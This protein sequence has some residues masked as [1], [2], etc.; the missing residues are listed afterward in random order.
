MTAEALFKAMADR[1]RQR[2][3]MVLRKQE[4]NVT[5]LVEVL[6]QPQSTVSRHLKILRDAGLIRDRRNGATILY[7][8]PVAEVNGDAADL[9]ARLLEWSSIQPLAAS[10]EAR[11]DAVIRLRSDMSRRFFDRVGEQWDGLREE[12]FGSSFH[13]E[14]FIT[15]LPHAWAVADIGTGTGYLLPTLARHFRCVIGVDPVDRM[16]ET[17]RR[18]VKHDGMCNVELRRGE[19]AQL[20]IADGSVDLALAVLVL[21]HVPTPRDA[22]LE[23]HRIVRGAGRVLIVEQTAHENES[24]RQRMQDRWWGFE[25]DEFA[26]LLGRAGFD[27]VETRE[28]ATVE[29]AEDAP[30]LFVVTGRKPCGDDRMESET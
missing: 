7:S 20:P 24:F 18:R 19:L 27:T 23:L 26:G 15:L 3:L 12:S 13:L 10:M 28:L 5:E 17:A 2:T 25:P 9:P 30:H 6:H 1:T 22:L 29:R 21:H 11:L 4:L 14:A 16:L 8:V